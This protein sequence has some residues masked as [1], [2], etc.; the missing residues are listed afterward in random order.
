MAVIV[1]SNDSAK[2]MSG[3]L[4]K[5]SRHL[6]KWRKRWMV[7][8]GWILSSYKTENEQKQTECIDLKT[9][10]DVCKSGSLSFDIYNGNKIAFSFR[11][12]TYEN[13]Q[14]WIGHLSSAI[15]KAK[16]HEKIT[17]QYDGIRHIPS[18]NLFKAPKTDHVVIV[19][20]DHETE[21]VDTGGFFGVSTTGTEIRKQVFIHTNLRLRKNELLKC[22]FAR[23]RGSKHP[24]LLVYGDW[25]EFDND[26]VIRI[27]LICTDDD[28]TGQKINKVRLQ[29]KSWGELKNRMCNEL[30][31]PVIATVDDITMFCIEYQKNNIKYSHSRNNCRKFMIALC[32]FL[33]IQFPDAYPLEDKW[34]KIQEVSQFRKEK[35]NTEIETLDNDENIVSI[36]GNKYDN[37]NEND[38]FEQ[39]YDDNI[40]GQY[41]GQYFGDPIYSQLRDIVCCFVSKRNKID[42]FWY[43][44]DMLFVQS[45]EQ[46]NVENDRYFGYQLKVSYEQLNCIDGTLNKSAD[47]V[48]DALQIWQEA[49]DELEIN[50]EKTQNITADAWV[51]MKIKPPLLHPDECT[52][53]LSYY[54]IYLQ[55]LFSHPKIEYICAALQFPIKLSALVVKLAGRKEVPA[56]TE[57]SRN[58]FLRTLFMRDNRVEEKTNADDTYAKRKE[59]YLWLKNTVG[60]E[61]YYNVL[62]RNGYDDM[63]SMINITLDDL[64]VMGVDKIGHRRKIYKNAQM[65]ACAWVCSNARCRNQNIQ[66]ASVCALC[67]KERNFS[68]QSEVE[69]P[70]VVDT[71]K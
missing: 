63:D 12:S 48:F 21:Y 6:G 23:K 34:Y 10:S 22:K 42:D 20:N 38:L 16:E 36:H 64:Q 13:N 31:F 33:K 15:V 43:E 5:K 27:D 57:H 67:D 3:W 71:A 14:L 26:Q 58:I 41:Y 39:L 17:K 53:F 25:P 29:S 54:S 4:E 46:L 28:K 35:N 19:K 18:I 61:Q 24:E 9:Y 2:S 8:K 60:L 50:K 47:T 68:N 69:G 52:D 55:A 40:L 59:L 45:D 30:E 7:S 1:Q 56:Q 51:R 11:A 49:R 32:E 66:S 62:M 65:T 37:L 70:N 44:F